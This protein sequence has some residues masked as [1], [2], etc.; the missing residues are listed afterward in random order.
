MRLLPLKPAAA[1]NKASS[2]K[3]LVRSSQ[4]IEC[5]QVTSP[6]CSKLA[7]VLVRHL[8]DLWHLPGEQLPGLAG[9]AP[10]LGALAEDATHAITDLVAALMDAFRWALFSL[11]LFHTC[12]S[13]P[14]THRTDCVCVR[15][16]Q[17][18]P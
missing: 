11:L 18:G 8:P 14:P 7:A 10:Q 1:R 13:A 15:F 2:P 12:P 4:W 9:I 5:K 6:W 3:L 17:L 16:P